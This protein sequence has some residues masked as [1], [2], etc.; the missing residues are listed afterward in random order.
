VQP[1]IVNP[2]ELREKYRENLSFFGTIDVQK[3]LPFGS[4][5]DVKKE[6]MAHIET[7][8]YNG[9]LI[10]APSHTILP[11]IPVENI[12][13]MCETAKKYGRYPIIK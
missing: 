5:E 8:G 7:C 6:V 3:T 4:A 1:S 9:G 10:I 2:A 13:A 11:G 12:L